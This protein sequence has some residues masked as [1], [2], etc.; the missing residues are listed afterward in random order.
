MQTEALIDAMNALGYAVAN[1][2]QRELAH[3]Y[4]VF[5]ARARRATFEFVSAN[6]VWQ[7]TG[8]PVVPPLTVRKV[9][10]REGARV[11]EVRIGFIGLTGYNPAFQAPGPAGRRIVTIDPAGAFEKHL[12]DLRRKADV[13]VALASLD[14]DPSRGLARRVKEIDLLLA[15]AGSTQTRA[16]DFPEDTQLGRTR[17]MYVGDQGKNLGEVRLFFNAQR[18]IASTQRATIYLGTEWPEDP[19]LLRLMERTK[20]AVNDEN[21]ART[22]AQSPFASAP[23]VAPGQAGFTGSERCAECHE[24]EVDVWK[25]TAHAHAFQALVKANQDYNPGCLGCHTMG[26]GAPGGFV[27]PQMTPKLRDVGCEACHGPSSR[28]PEGGGAY[29]KVDTSIC[30]TCHTPENSPDFDPATYIPKVRHWT[31]VGSAAATR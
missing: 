22:E 1:F 31:D 2:S 4:D 29:G 8:Q 20:A 16:D 14:L 19:D 18:G 13:I 12:P 17:L 10:L 26:Y 9:A 6:M 21:R 7:D 27:S 5:Q 30:V 11:R 25:G 23:P 28:H 15:G 24:Q 3:G